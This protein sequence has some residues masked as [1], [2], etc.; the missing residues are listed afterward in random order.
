M[1]LA[2]VRGSA[3]PL[4]RYA[5]AAALPL[6]VNS[7]RP[8]G[9]RRAPRQGPHQHACLVALLVLC[10]CGLL[11][12]TLSPSSSSS[13]SS[14]SG[15]SAF[16]E[17]PLAL[18]LRWPDAEDS[19]PVE[20]RYDVRG[21][22]SAVNPRGAADVESEET[23]TRGSAGV[24][25]QLRGDVEGYDR[26]KIS[27]ASIESRQTDSSFDREA[28]AREE[29][30]SLPTLLSSSHATI[31]DT[32][33]GARASAA[34]DEED[35]RG[36]LDMMV[37]VLV[38]TVPRRNGERYLE[39]V[40]NKWTSEAASG[41]RHV[42]KIF[43]VFDSV[44][45]PSHSVLDDVIVKTKRVEHVD[46]KNVGPVQDLRPN[47]A[48]PANFYDNFRPNSHE[49]MQ[50]EMVLRGIERIA[51]NGT[52]P[53][54]LLTEDDFLPCDH[55]V[56]DLLEDI[57]RIPN[58]FTSYRCSMGLGC[59]LIQRKDLLAFVAWTRANVAVSKIDTLSSI[60]FA[61]E[62]TRN[63]PGKFAAGSAHLDGASHFGS[64]RRNY[65]KKELRTIHIGISSSFG[66]AHAKISTAIA[67]QCG[68]EYDT[69]SPVEAPDGT[70]PDKFDARR[71][72]DHFA[73]PCHELLVV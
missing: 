16:V 11:W 57:A 28:E 72:M 68:Q 44:T 9:R 51:A 64:A 21:Q 65:V 30:D 56:R 14:S 4:H 13:S 48:E 33:E 42:G 43:V 37:D 18:K 31:H 41:R 50:T 45:H 1:A 40:I 69:S 70:F 55:F 22:E 6:S 7:G 34:V 62:D 66:V 73:S 54:V 32:Q 2:S 53:L 67:G 61:K 23:H 12:S 36:R 71:C 58:D 15:S 17:T 63:F 26:D 38:P 35:C 19:E 29:E 5:A 25:Q 49:R 39:Q 47:S 10:S 46:Y 60:F 20:A 24:A 3:L 27:V 8:P 59:L 52:A